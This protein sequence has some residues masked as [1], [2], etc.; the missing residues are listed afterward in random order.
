[1]YAASSK[2]LGRSRLLVKNPNDG[3]SKL[4]V[5]KQKYRS[6]TY[7]FIKMPFFFG[8]FLMRISNFWVQAECSEIFFKFHS[9]KF[10]KHS[11]T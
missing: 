3:N 1:M 5:S 7:S 6:R 8:S 10:L 9:Q 11:K 2:Q 4:I